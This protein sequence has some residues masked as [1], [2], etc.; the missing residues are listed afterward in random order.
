MKAEQ[1]KAFAKCRAIAMALPGVTERISWGHPN[2]LVGGKMF[3]G[4]G[5]GHGG[6]HVG[7]KVSE[8]SF[9]K[10]DARFKPMMSVGSWK[11]LEDWEIY[12]FDWDR[13]DDW[14]QLRQLIEISWELVFATLSKGKQDRVMD[15]K[16]KKASGTRRPRKTA[17]RSSAR[18][19]GSRS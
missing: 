8:R 6:P 15:A 9:E 19:S 13:A 3:A 14:A 5:I 4:V 10:G 1:K 2:W 11:G 12:F 7:F 16:P 18:R 17:R